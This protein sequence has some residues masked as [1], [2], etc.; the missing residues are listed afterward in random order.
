MRQLLPPPKLWVSEKMENCH[1][2][3][4]LTMV[5]ARQILGG[6]T[7]YFKGIMPKNL[8]YTQKFPKKKLHCALKFDGFYR[9]PREPLMSATA[10]RPRVLQESHHDYI[11][12]IQ[13]ERCDNEKKNMG[14]HTF[15]TCCD[16]VKWNVLLFHY[17]CSCEGFSAETLAI[18]KG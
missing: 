12:S 11:R 3:S 9:S 18:C 1:G 8:H 13:K 17:V 4:L 15:T 2:D 7:Q 16:N 10:F 5:D 6:G 14:E